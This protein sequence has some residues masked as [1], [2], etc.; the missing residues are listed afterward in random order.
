MIRHYLDRG[1]ALLRD[2][3]GGTAI[4]FALAM[5]AVVGAA[6][7]SLEYVSAS[8]NRA[9]MQ[10]TA[11]AAALA[12]A[13][14]LS[15]AQ[16]SS[17]NAGTV[18]Q[19][20]ARSELALSLK[21]LTFTV[22]TNVIDNNTS[23]QVKISTSYQPI[24]ARIVGQDAMAVKVEAVARISAGYPICLLGLDESM[25]G[26]VHLESEARLTAPKCAIYSDSKNVQGVQAVQN[27]VVSAALICSAGGKVGSNANFN[28]TP[29]TDCPIVKD[30][31]ASRPAP[32]VGDCVATNKTVDGQ[33]VTLYPGTYCGGLTVTKDARVRLSPGV[34]VIKDGPLTVDRGASFQGTNVGFYLTGK[35]ATM[36]LGSETSISLTAPKDGPLAGI[37]L[38]EDRAAPSKQAHKILSNDAPVLLGTFY[39]S[40]NK[41][42]IDA[43]KPIADR[44]AYTI[45][46]ARQVQLFSGPNLVLN[47]DYGSTDIPVPAGVG[48]SGAALVK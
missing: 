8:N 30:P 2:R 9:K 7:V 38:F 27:A 28:P 40:Q 10:A 5:P 20:Y 32:P 15:L 11:D 31:L 18:A 22:E 13:R 1:L 41:L 36:L 47:T 45:I 12:A 14:E 35:G 6:A 34:Y 42:V 19:N 37:L 23:V 17:S 21:N 33:T 44:S 39:L 26:T 25:P 16:N 48:P 3:R 4:I 46:V 24:V 43:D 29:I